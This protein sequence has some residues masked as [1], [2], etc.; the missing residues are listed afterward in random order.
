MVG[1]P[2]NYRE[3]KKGT[4]LISP[5]TDNPK[6]Y[7]VLKKLCRGNTKSGQMTTIRVLN[8]DGKIEKVNPWSTNGVPHGWSMVQPIA[9]NS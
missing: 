2:F 1:E 5:E 6:V 9:T 4:I 3:T 7:L 8:Q